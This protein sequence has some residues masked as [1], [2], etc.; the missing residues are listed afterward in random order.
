MNGKMKEKC[1][2]NAT[3]GLKILLLKRREKNY[4]GLEN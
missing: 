2:S 4:K 1:I 3:R